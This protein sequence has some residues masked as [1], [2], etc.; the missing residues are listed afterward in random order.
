MSARKARAQTSIQRISEGFPKIELEAA[1]GQP[2]CMIRKRA[3]KPV[4][5]VLSFHGL[6]QNR[7]SFDLPSRSLANYLVWRG[8]EVS[9][10]EFRGHGLSGE[11]GS[12]YPESFSEK[13]FLDAPAFVRTARRLA[14]RRPFVLGHSLGATV[15]YAMP[16][17]LDDEIAGIVGVGGPS[18]LGLG[19]GPLR[20]VARLLAAVYPVSIFRLIP[21]AHP[22]HLDWLGRVF[23]AMRSVFDSPIVP[24]P[25][26]L[27]VPR[28]I[29]PDILK[30][31]I[32]LSFNRTGFSVVKQ[33]VHWIAYGRFE[34]LDGDDSFWRNARARS[35]PLYLVV[36]DR[37]G[38]VPRESVVPIYEEAASV[39]K[40][41]EVLGRDTCGVSFGHI[42]I[43][44]GR[45]APRI[46]WSRIARWL[47]AR[48]A[49][50]VRRR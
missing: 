10:A 25:Y 38:G 4:A 26:R 3:S 44:Y 28:S 45:A 14:G 30:S 21:D 32:E 12:R 9:L 35:V 43:L 23:W 39:D 15:A 50:A 13:V 2:L 20:A 36:G 7:Y 33:A 40:R 17:E 1:D 48:A 6:A 41:F 8:F 46:V 34:D 47:L 18:H 31:A 19:L 24:I 27:W 22:F 37:D 11:L 16:Q 5:S 42:D 29:E 49:R